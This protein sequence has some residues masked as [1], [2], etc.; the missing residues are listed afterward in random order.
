MITADKVDSP[1]VLY[2][3]VLLS[4]NVRLYVGWS[5]IENKSRKQFAAGEHVQLR[6]QVK[7]VRQ[8][9]KSWIK[10]S[11][12][13]LSTRKSM[14]SAISFSTLPLGRFSR[15]ILLKAKPGRHLSLKHERSAH[16]CGRYMCDKI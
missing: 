5:H 13:T 3:H 9:I 7:E 6:K 8:A 10:L 15:I 16:V 12:P 11:T 4:N 1:G 2:F 14:E